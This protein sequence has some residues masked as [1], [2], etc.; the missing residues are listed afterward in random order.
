MIIRYYGR[1]KSH[2]NM[3]YNWYGTGN[4]FQPEK[5]ESGK[6]YWPQSDVQLML[7]SM[8]MY[9]DQEPFHTYYMTV[10]GHM[11]YDVN[12]NQMA[13]KNYGQVAD[14][15]IPR[16]QK[17][18]WRASWSWKKHWRRWLENWKTVGLQ[19]IR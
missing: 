1:D 19:I 9:M 3:G 15:H 12:S 8:D 13:Y 18:I 5:T 4:W 14:L 16:R 2:P 6:D 11:M 10:S 17:D 7:Q